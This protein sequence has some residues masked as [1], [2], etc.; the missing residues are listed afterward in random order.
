M[1]LDRD[2]P[3]GEL[4][5][6]IDHS[7]ALVMAKLKRSQRGPALYPAGRTAAEPIQRELQRRQAPGEDT[8]ERNILLVSAARS[9]DA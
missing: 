7:Y 2:V 9:R 1:A 8:G 3:R 5:R 6:L 4:E